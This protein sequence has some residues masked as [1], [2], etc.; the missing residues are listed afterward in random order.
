MNQA[1]NNERGVALLAAI[2]A[3][4]LIGS[5]MTAAAASSILEFRMAT[6]GR[7]MVQAF[8]TAEYGLIDVVT[9]W[10]QLTYNVLA[11][12]DSS[13]VT[14]TTP[15]GTGIYE[16]YVKR[17]SDEV[18]LVKVAGRDTYGGSVQQL[19][20]LV[21]L[22]P[23]NINVSSALT[24]QGPTTIGGSATL[25]GNDAMP[26]GWSDCP[27]LESGMSGIATSDTSNLTLQG[28][29]SDGSC[30]AG[31]PNINEDT[32]VADSTFFDYGDAMWDDLVKAANKILTPG[33]YTGVQPSYSGGNCNTSDPKNW[34]DPLD[35]T[36]NC[37]MYFP[38]I[39]V[40]G[41]L[42]VNGDYGQGFLL[43]DG[44]LS[45]Q[46]GFEFFGIVIVKGAISTTG[47]GGHFNGSVMAA[48]VNLDASKVLGNASVNFSSCSIDKAI[49]FA[50]TATPL[51]S[52]NWFQVYF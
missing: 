7:R 8:S 22:T 11:T 38:V 40:N 4:V 5:L 2:V 34:G 41:N 25:S 26:S 15:A 43:V 16:G 27:P 20:S 10:D 1:T 31:S 28:S 23:I 24:T 45:V 12:Y 3:I 51:T 21:R 48:N 39:Y 44:D 35:Q 52:R 50:A 18:F 32:A 14:D 46:G 33:T 47:T 9:N 6:N 36:S 13:Y 29:C 49:K 17:L 37:A 19:G 30:I 42:N